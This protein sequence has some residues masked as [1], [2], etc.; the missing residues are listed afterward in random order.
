MCLCVRV[1]VFLVH[2]SLLAVFPSIPPPHFLPLPLALQT[3]PRRQSNG[4]FDRAVFYSSEHLVLLSALHLGI[5]KLTCH[6]H[7]LGAVAHGGGG[8]GG[9]L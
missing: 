1:R 9:I 5:Q 8:G 4:E 3:L 2:R 7:G 6:L